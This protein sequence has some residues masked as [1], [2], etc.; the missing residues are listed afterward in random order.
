MKCGVVRTLLIAS[1]SMWGVSGIP[2]PE[3]ALLVRHTV[4]Q[5][6]LAPSGDLPGLS[7]FGLESV[8]KEIL[9]PI[10]CKRPFLY[11]LADHVQ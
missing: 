4:R 6:V 5:R 8:Q 11:I 7:P 3:P 10:L 1:V 2:L 9:L